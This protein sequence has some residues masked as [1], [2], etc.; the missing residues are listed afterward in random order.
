MALPLPEPPL[1]DGVVRLRPWSAHDVDALVAA[2]SD[3]EIRKWTR[4]PAQRDAEAALRWI[5]AEHLRRDRGLALDL[6]ISPAALGDDT[7]LGEVGM[8]PLAGGPSRAELGW[9]VAAAHRRQGIATRAVGL[10]GGWLQQALAFTDLFA[11]VDPDNPASVW[12]AEA[13]NLRLR[14]RQ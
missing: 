13:N 9:W 1:T 12:V 3:E 11:E 6:V 4:V 5:A 14:I 10:F 2:W 7:V 8:V